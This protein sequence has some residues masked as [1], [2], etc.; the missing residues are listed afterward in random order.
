MIHISKLIVFILCFAPMFLFG[1]VGIG[2]TT[3]HESSLIQIDGGSGDKGLLIPTVELSDIYSKDPITSPTIKESLIVF[4]TGGDILEGFYFWDGEKWGK[5]ID[6]NDNR[7]SIKFSSNSTS[8]NLNTSNYS[9]IGIFRDLVWNDDSNF[10]IKQN[11]FIIEVLVTGTY[12]V[13]SYL[14]MV[15][16]DDSG[17]MATFRINGVVSPSIGARYISDDV[18]NAGDHNGMLITG[19][20]KLE[21]GDELEIVVKRTIST[22]SYNGPTTL[23]NDGNS[24]A[25]I[26]FVKQD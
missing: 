6:N 24:F 7:P 21:E 16:A 4:N 12:Q 10:F 23:Y 25:E 22:L 5:V 20:L 26:V 19:L 2:T 17:L 13:N 15:I 14:S 3:P 9:P 8:Q 1:Q 11:R 18:Q